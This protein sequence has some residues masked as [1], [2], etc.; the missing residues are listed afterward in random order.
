[1]TDQS[2]ADLLAR[3][4][5]CLALG[6]SANENE[7][8][9]AIGKAR[10]LMDAHGITDEDVS[11]SEISEEKV[12]G[13]CAQ[14]APLWETALSMTVEHALGVRALIGL[15][16]ERIY[17][18]AGAA[19][20]VA[21]YA[22]GVLFRKLKAAR[23]EYTRVKLKRCN[24]ARKRQ[25]ADVFCEAWAGAVY[26]QVKRLMPLQPVDDRVSLYIE[27][28]YG[29]HLTSVG[30]RAASTKGRDTSND[31]WAGYDRGREVELH[32]AVGGGANGSGK[33]LTHG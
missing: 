11:L 25:R 17:I 3:I 33:A 5:K 31:Y 4:R 19:P 16:G 27:Q 14:R 1:M 18:G 28:R 29:R 21:T 9:A 24:L 13:N 26:S 30:P 8:A 15:D 32:G 22:F 7:A 20:M 12:K 10:A 2:R 6:K 23:T